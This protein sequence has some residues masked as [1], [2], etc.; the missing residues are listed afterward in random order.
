MHYS[1]KSSL[2]YAHPTCLWRKGGLTLLTFWIRKQ[3]CTAYSLVLFL[4]NL[5]MKLYHDFLVAI[6]STARQG[7]FSRFVCPSSWSSC[8]DISTNPTIVILWASFH[9][10]LCVCLV[11][12]YCLFD[13]LIESLDRNNETT[14]SPNSPLSVAVQLQKGV[15]PNSMMFFFSFL[16]SVKL[17]SC[18]PFLL[19]LRQR[20]AWFAADLP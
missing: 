6:Q 17:N 4:L 13:V 5:L 18:S 9:F 2:T 20:G 19:T 16:F 3:L 8:L 1:A 7:N 15:S 14:V 12:F 11:F 10:S